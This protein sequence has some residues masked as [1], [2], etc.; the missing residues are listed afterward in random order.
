MILA[1]R[2]AKVPVFFIQAE[3]DYDTAPSRVLFEQMQ[4][5]GKPARLRIFPPNGTTA[6]QGHAFCRGGAD[7][8]WGEDVL[9]FLHET[10][11]AQ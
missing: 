4:K 2:N 8:A 11:G 7:P 10:M 6:E 9:A 3:N 5:A 1:A